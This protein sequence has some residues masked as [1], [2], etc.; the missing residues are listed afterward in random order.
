MVAS[1]KALM[2]WPKMTVM[3]GCETPLASAPTV[4]RSMSSTSVPSAYRNSPVNG[5]FFPASPPPFPLPLPTSF[6]STPSLPLA[7][8]AASIARELRLCGCVLRTTRLPLRGRLILLAPPT[9]GIYGVR[10]SYR[11]VCRVRGP[12]PAH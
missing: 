9:N 3:T 2:T 10:W 11:G 4:P 6:L 8:P 7:P 1:P 12:K 5:T